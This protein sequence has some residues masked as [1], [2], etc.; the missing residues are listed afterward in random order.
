MEVII[1]KILNHPILLILLSLLCVLLFFSVLKGLIKITIFAIAL[2]GLYFGYLHFFEEQYPLPEFDFA[3]LDTF[4]DK[5]RE[6]IVDDLNLSVDLNMTIQDRNQTI[7][8][9]GF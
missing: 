8:D 4:R 7:S 1:E 6:F 3:P 9:E 2:G 5:A